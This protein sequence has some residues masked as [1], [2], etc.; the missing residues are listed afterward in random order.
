MAN[1]THVFAL[2]AIKIIVK[3]QNPK[4]EIKSHE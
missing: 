2:D 4:R 1:C 3:E